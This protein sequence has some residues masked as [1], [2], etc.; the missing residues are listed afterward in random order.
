M[1]KEKLVKEYA[2]AQVGAPYVYGGTGRPCTPLYR[3]ARVKQYPRYESLIRDNCPVLSG[4]QKDCA[5]CPH[6]GRK[7][8]DCA[9]LVRRALQQMDVQLPSG[10]SSQWLKGKW[11]EKGKVDARTA[12][13]LCVVFREGGAPMKH[14]GLC[15]GDGSVVDA[16][17]HRTG[18]VRSKF[19]DYPWTH[20]ALPEPAAAAVKEEDAQAPRIEQMQRLLLMKGFSLPLYGADG[21]WG[22]ETRTAMQAY[23]KL[24][25]LP[26]T[27]CWDAVT[28]DSLMKGDLSLA[29]RVRRLEER[30]DVWEGRASA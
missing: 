23:Q 24:A 2:L 13:T 14:V 7:C 6:Q 22:Q 21:K 17:G 5:A 27:D 4:R 11:R 18:V 12:G 10:A 1:D 16:R 25:G 29:G 28:L 19:Q 30:M 3:Q 15:L 26:V 8:F 9:Q 20:Y